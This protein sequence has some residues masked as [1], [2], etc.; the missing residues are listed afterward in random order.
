MI[1]T[2]DPSQIDLPAGKDSGLTEAIDILR[3]IDEVDHIAFTKADVVRRE[4]VGR[5][6]EAYEAAPRNGGRS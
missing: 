2:G 5:I 4:L 3:D 1:V 6:V